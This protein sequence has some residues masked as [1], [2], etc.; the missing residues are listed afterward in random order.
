MQRAGG[1]RP[2]GQE[3]EGGEEGRHIGRAAA[4]IACCPSWPRAVAKAEGD[5]CVLQVGDDD[6]ALGVSE[7]E[8]E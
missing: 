3:E 4:G 1:A 8:G 5:V 2:S 7:R 6:A